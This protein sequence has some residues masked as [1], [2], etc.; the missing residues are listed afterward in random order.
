MTVSV[1][2]QDA[3]FPANGQFRVPKDARASS[4]SQTSKGGSRWISKRCTC[5][6]F[7]GAAVSG[8]MPDGLVAVSTQLG[9]L[10][11]NSPQP[12]EIIDEPK[13]RLGA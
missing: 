1:G 9:Q 11:V 3:R 13:I 7:L 12:S 4:R 2:S 6:A 10:R 5:W 8:S